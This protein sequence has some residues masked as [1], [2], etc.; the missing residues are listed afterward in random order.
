[1]R[2][3]WLL[4]C[5]S[6]P[7]FGCENFLNINPDS[8]VVN[9][10]MFSTP[11]GVEDALYGVYMSMVK[12]DMYGGKMSVVVPEILAQNFTT[13]DEHLFYFSRLEFNNTSIKYLCRDML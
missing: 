9:E 10:D 4:L 5:M 13:S 7:F 12:E 2:K 11:E 8:E 3:I 6:F 1:M